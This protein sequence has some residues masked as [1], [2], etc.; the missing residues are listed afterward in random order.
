M[1][2]SLKCLLQ[3]W[4]RKP[5]INGEKRPFR[6]RRLQGRIRLPTIW[7]ASVAKNP[8]QRFRILTV[9]DTND[10]ALGF[11]Q[12]AQFPGL[13]DIPAQQD[14]K[15]SLPAGA[16]ITLHKY[17]SA[18]Q[19][20]HF[21][22]RN[23]LADPSHAEE[24]AQRTGDQELRRR[25]QRPPLC[26]RNGNWVRWVRGGGRI[27]PRSISRQAAIEEEERDHHNSG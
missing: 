3:F 2:A 7:P 8:K 27:S 22:R 24:R 12:G 21:F 25:V 16:F 15:F 1:F 20:Q 17:V 9:R 11:R 13:N 5:G 26:G 6:I 18:Q 10:H 23:L 19:G 4:K 14:E